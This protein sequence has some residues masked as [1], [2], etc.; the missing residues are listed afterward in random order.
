MLFKKLAKEWKESKKKAAAKFGVRLT[1]VMLPLWLAAYLVDKLPISSVAL[2]MT[3]GCLLG[4]AL[5]WFL[6]NA[7][8][9]IS[10]EYQAWVNEDYADDRY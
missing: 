7:S 2:I 10:E 8:D 1:F 6:E 9:A 3:I 4:D 5:S